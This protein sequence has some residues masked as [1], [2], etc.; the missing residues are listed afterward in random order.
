VLGR[1][2][3]YV[4]SRIFSLF[5]V[6]GSFTHVNNTSALPTESRQRAPRR[7][8]RYSDDHHDATLWVAHDAV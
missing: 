1:S 2:E 4:S 5:I 8:R 3:F 7:C 6:S